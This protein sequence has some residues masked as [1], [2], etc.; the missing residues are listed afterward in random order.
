MSWGFER[1]F[2]EMAGQADS[3][4]RSVAIT[5]TSRNV[6]C[7]CWMSSKVSIVLISIEVN[8]SSR[9]SFG[10]QKWGESPAALFSMRNLISWNNFRPVCYHHEEE[11]E[12]LVSSF[13]RTD[14]HA[15]TGPSLIVPDLAKQI[16]SLLRLSAYLSRYLMIFLIFSLMK[17]RRQETPAYRLF[18]LLQSQAIL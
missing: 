6:V 10:F 5:E 15:K 1:S 13:C 4:F 9:A 12:L 2:V 16:L 11:E 14:D 17:L 18:I 3:D 7:E 8:F